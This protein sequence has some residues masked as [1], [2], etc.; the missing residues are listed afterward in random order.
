[1]DENTILLTITN[2][3]VLD[4]NAYYLEMHKKRKK[5]PI[6]KP[7]HPSLNTW[8]MV[9]KRIA[10]NKHKQDW[11]DFVKHLS[12]VNG[13][14]GMMLSKYE[15]EVVTYMPSKR[16]ADPDNYVPKF[17]LDGLVEAGVLVD[18][19]GEHMECL[20]LKTRYDKENPRTEIY[21]M[22]KQEE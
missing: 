10:A 13:L 11:K 6:S 20:R 5:P 19:D 18:D 16:R 2:K 4:Y 7:T 8:A 15:M 1:M 12:I 17:I 9:G 22:S 14:D 21:I 3:E